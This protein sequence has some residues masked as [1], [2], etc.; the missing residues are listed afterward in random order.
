MAQNDDQGSTPRPLRRRAVPG[1]DDYAVFGRDELE[2]EIENYVRRNS[3]IS[4]EVVE[5]MMIDLMAQVRDEVMHRWSNAGLSVSTN[6]NTPGLDEEKFRALFTLWKAAT[7]TPGRF[8]KLCNYLNQQFE[9]A[10]ASKG[11]VMRTALWIAGILSALATVVGLL[12][13]VISHHW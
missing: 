4:R 6:V 8:E 2:R 5:K 9:E 13:N 11:K 10:E 1:L 7:V 12:L 3:L